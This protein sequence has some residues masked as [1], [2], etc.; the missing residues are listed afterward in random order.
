MLKNSDLVTL[1]KMNYIHEQDTKLQVWLD[2][3]LLGSKHVVMMHVRRKFNK[4]NVLRDV[5]DK[6]PYFFSQCFSC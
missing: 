1:F 3:E 5:N 4:F 6:I 2:E